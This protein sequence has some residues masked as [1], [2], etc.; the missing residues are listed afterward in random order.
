M[1]WNGRGR[2]L[3][4]NRERINRIVAQHRPTIL[5]VCE[6]NL[7]QKV[8]DQLVQIQSYKMLDLKARYIDE[9]K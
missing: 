5:A 3:E 6:A 2:Y 1:H 7:R 8:D 9:I 4:N